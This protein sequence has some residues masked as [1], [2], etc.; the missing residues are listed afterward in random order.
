M[1][2]EDTFFSTHIRTCEVAKQWRTFIDE[3]NRRGVENVVIFTSQKVDADL[4]S[5]SCE[6]RGIKMGSLEEERYSIN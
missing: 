3:L 5:H 1:I 4:V 2:H 6:G